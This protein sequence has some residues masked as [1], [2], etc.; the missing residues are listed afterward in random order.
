[1]KDV[2]FSIADW[3]KRAVAPMDFSEFGHPQSEVGA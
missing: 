3:L 1:M 2:L